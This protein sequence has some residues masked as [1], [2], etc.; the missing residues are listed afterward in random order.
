MG[1]WNES[2]KREI[3]V[4]SKDGREKCQMWEQNFNKILNNRVRGNSKINKSRLP[5]FMLST[6]EE[7]EKNLLPQNMM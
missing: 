6:M 4:D 2:K 3:L 1:V 7:F 5:F